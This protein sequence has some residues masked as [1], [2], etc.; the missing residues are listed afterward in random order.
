[1]YGT[2]GQQT[3]PDRLT[4]EVHG[5]GTAL[6]YSATKLRASQAEDIAQDPQQGHIRWDIDCMILAIDP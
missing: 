4:F 5:A 6:A 2:D 3:R 1:M